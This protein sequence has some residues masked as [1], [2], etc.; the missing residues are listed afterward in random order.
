MKRLF[1]YTLMLVLGIGFGVSLSGCS[2]EPDE[3][4]YYT[5]TGEMMSEYLYGH[6]ELSSFTA[7]VERD[8]MMDLLSAY[9]A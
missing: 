2:D 1:R 3:A 6:S 7:V 4:T 8:G 5:L 9:V